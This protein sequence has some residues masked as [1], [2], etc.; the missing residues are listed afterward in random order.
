MADILEVKE[1]PSEGLK[2][3]GC[4]SFGST[5]G[6]LGLLEGHLGITWGVSWGRLGVTWGITW[7]HLGVGGWALGVSWGP[8]STTL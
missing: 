3:P 5:W 2:S 6:Q 4:E 7:G 8:E 1:L